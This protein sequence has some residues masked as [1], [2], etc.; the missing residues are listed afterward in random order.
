MVQRPG[1]GR[2]HAK[3]PGMERLVPLE[4]WDKGQGP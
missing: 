1:V 4:E 3:H 2:E